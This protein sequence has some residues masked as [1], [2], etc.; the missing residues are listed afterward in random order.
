[1][2]NS[3]KYKAVF[4][5]TGILLL[6]ALS[7]AKSQNI[8]QVFNHTTIS[9]AMRAS[10][11]GDKL[12][13]AYVYTEWSI[14]SVRMLD[15]T[16]VDSRV[17]HELVSDY[18]NVAI[19]A[20]RKKKFV[21]EYDIHIFP[22][23]LVMDWTGKVILRSKGYK[24]NEEFLKTIAKT[25]SNSRFL[26]QSIDSLLLTTNAS[27]VLQVLDSIKYYRDD[28]AAKN[29]AKKYLDRKKTDWRHPNNMYLIKEYFTLDKK[30]LK[31]IS[32]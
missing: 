29:L 30:Y 12:V 2:S 32:K 10:K 14:P 26:R 22:T 11:H 28:Y 4:L 17:V 19:D 24:N 1:M 16:F 5:L 7:E 23:M 9:K 27:N 31:F 6:S 15:T 13:F 18:E 8:P 20:S 25:R 21:T 3:S